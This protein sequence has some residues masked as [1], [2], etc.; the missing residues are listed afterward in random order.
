[1]ALVA[2]DNLAEVLLHHHVQLTFQ[3]SEDEGVLAV[4]RYDQRER[5]RLRNDFDRRV[6]LGQAEQTG[7]GAFAFPVPMLNDAD[8]TIFRVAHRYRNGV[9]HADR[10]NAALLDPLTRLYLAAV[11]RAWCR[12]QRGPTAD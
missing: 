9:Y 5:D 11:G 8:A 3:A 6:T 4:G 1:M 10:H 7:V 2:T 12:A